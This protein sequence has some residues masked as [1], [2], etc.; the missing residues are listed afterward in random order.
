[1]AG[2]SYLPFSFSDKTI[3]IPKDNTAKISMLYGK[4]V[5]VKIVI[6]S[7]SK[8]YLQEAES[9][10]LE[11]TSTSGITLTPKEGYDYVELPSYRSD[12]GNYTIKITSIIVT[13]SPSETE[14]IEK[15]ETPTIQIT[16][17]GKN[18][19]RYDESSDIY[20]F[21]ANPNAAASNATK[22]IA[23]KHPRY[24]HVGF[25]AKPGYITKTLPGLTQ[26][27][28][29]Y[30][31]PK[32]SSYWLKSEYPVIDPI[33]QEEI[34]YDKEYTFGIVSLN[35]IHGFSDKVTVRYKFEKM[36]P[37]AIDIE[38]SKSNGSG[39]ENITQ[40]NG[41]WIVE[42]SSNSPKISF[43]LDPAQTET[44][45]TKDGDDP[46]SSSTIYNE[47]EQIGFNFSYSVNPGQINE[48][49]IFSR[50]FNT[51]TTSSATTT[52]KYYSS[53]ITSVIFKKVAGSKPSAPA[54]KDVTIDG[55]ETLTNEKIP[56]RIGIEKDVM[57]NFGIGGQYTSINKKVFTEKP[58][59]NVDTSDWEAITL[60]AGDSYTFTTDDLPS[61]STEA[62]IGIV[63]TTDTGTSDPLWIHV[64]LKAP[65]APK[66]VYNS[67]SYDNGSERV[68]FGASLD[69]NFTVGEDASVIE[70]C[71]ERGSNS[72]GSEPSSNTERHKL[73]V[74][75][76]APLKIDAEKIDNGRLFYRAGREVEGATVWSEWAWTDFKRES[77][78]PVSL[79]GKY[80]TWLGPVGDGTLVHV[81]E[82]LRIM[83]YYTTNATLGVSNS[84]PSYL[85][86][87]NKDGYVIKLLGSEVINGSWPTSI[88][89]I[90]NEEYESNNYVLKGVYGWVKF[91]N[92]ENNMPEIYLTQGSTA[93]SEALYDML[94]EPEISTDWAL[95]AK[96]EE[97]QN[98]VDRIKIDRVNDFSRYVTVRSL[99]W[100]GENNEFEMAD[101]T[102]IPLYNRFK[103]YPIANYTA[104]LDKNLLYC[105]RGFIGL[106]STTLSIFPNAEILQC[107]GTPNLFAPN[108]I[109]GDVDDKGFIDI[110]AV[111][112][113]VTFRVEGHADGK[114]GFT[115]TI[116]GGDEIEVVNN[117]FEVDLSD[118]N[119]KETMELVV[120]AHLNGM[121]S[122]APAKVRITKRKAEQV[123]SIEEFKTLEFA[124]PD[125]EK[126]YQITG[127]VVIEAKTDKYL[128]VRDYNDA[129]EA[130]MDENE[131]L[132][133]LL[134]K[135]TINPQGW[136]TDFEKGGD[137]APLEIGDVIY[138]FAIKP[139]HDRGNLLGNN[140][141]FVRTIKFDRHVTTGI[142]EY[143]TRNAAPTDNFEFDSR[144]RM[145][146]VKLHG[147]ELKPRVENT[148]PDTKDDFPYI[149]TLDLK[150]PTSM[151]M[152]VFVRTGFAAAY[153]E[154]VGFDLTGIAMIDND[155]DNDTEDKGKY[156]FALMS[157]EGTAQVAAPK[158]FI[159]GQEPTNDEVLDI[160]YT[161]TGTIKM[162]AEAKDTENNDLG[163]KENEKVTIYYTINGLDPLKDIYRHEY[164]ENAPELA[165]GDGDIEVRAFAAAPGKTPSAVVTRRFKKNSH[166]V[167]F[168]LNFLQSAKEGEAYRFTGDTKV[169]AMG[170]D[171]MFVVGRVGHYLP[172]ELKG[173]WA[174]KTDMNI[175]NG[176]LLTGFTVRF[177]ED[178][179]GNR[180]AVADEFESTF[181]SSG[182]ADAKFTHEPDVTDAL[183]IEKHPRRL[184]TLKGVTASASDAA[185]IRDID[186]W[187]IA[188][189]GDHGTHALKVGMLG[190]VD[191]YTVDEDG[192]KQ[193]VAE[194]FA[195]GATYDITGFVMLNDP[196]KEAKMEVWPL[197]AKLLR[198]TAAVTATIGDGNTQSTNGAGE[199]TASFEGMTMVSL[200][201]PSKNSKIYYAFDQSKG[202]SPD[203]LTW[204]EYQHEFA[205]TKDTYIHAKA[206]AP[207]AVESD[208]TH[209]VLTALGKSGDVEFNV[210][211]GDGVTTLTIAPAAGA[212]AGSTIWYSEGN[213]RSCN[214][215]YT[216]G[217][218]LKYTE[219]TTVYACIQEPGKAKGAVSSIRVMVVDMPQGGGNGNDN[220]KVSGKVVF[221]I[222]D[223]SD[224]TKVTVYL[225][226]EEGLTGTIYYLINPTEQV[227]PENGTKYE[228]PIEMK[229]G[230]RIMAIL[231]EAGKLAGE[232]TDIAVWLIPTDIDG[233]DAEER[234]G[235]IRAEGGSIIAPEGSE[236][237]D[238]TGRRV[239]AT[240]LHAGI[241]IVRTPGG[242]AVKVK[243]D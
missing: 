84:S 179:N 188:E 171:Y 22:G 106:A 50:V 99:K 153:A 186:K 109:K 234:E 103:E 59:G 191:V 199:I 221:T 46:T 24:A 112:D 1:M 158:V 88:T 152:D 45:Y 155:D 136:A 148:D 161:G 55:G 146:M 132:R 83:G 165:L 231:V 67:G 162:T 209:I 213:D 117:T 35:E 56:S 150:T 177:H 64:G 43:I 185:S 91:V 124:N 137:V 233:I 29:L 203:N 113:K 108:P 154:G 166:D 7:L 174:D 121:K 190:D 123:A 18:I 147:V 17:A 14:T 175:S 23:L 47:G 33:A 38:A 172:I 125:P 100:L 21:K 2:D 229:E 58:S 134:I 10:N 8:D 34:D 85:Y 30:N 74:N 163:L 224:P 60:G 151:R 222:D 82:E 178:E 102:R 119:D 101:G 201:C 218:E 181:K 220:A 217:T 71:M 104:N 87:L 4:I 149:Y 49:K 122:L 57:M 157:F 92:N 37:P 39:I 115:Y 78:T 223:T 77:V 143:E 26:S 196:S 227:T 15:T 130:E 116:D 240:G 194:G 81:D 66:I 5:K 51:G 114:S 16:D 96:G 133:R 97:R 184:V 111:S 167:Q 160:D 9:T 141:G 126:I 139:T 6:Q 120:Y 207:N 144:Y 202:F 75:D 156:A 127:K 232:P 235:N 44:R 31:I 238:I 200:V 198:K 54:L 131:H 225:A 118:L 80:T 168:I 145:V 239:N 176:D 98:P 187:S 105:V 20:Y 52:K 93:N 13:W 12:I 36:T 32:S 138:G 215:V 79:S 48:V 94:P 192:N 41:N 40:Q 129:P 25:Y 236:V 27:G 212:A 197:E 173:G 230:G 243:V 182:P 205:V 65:D 237:Y 73:I 90:S 42:Y 210:T 28:S 195:D 110:Q 159:D 19:V 242:K 214:K 128:Y 140:D 142:G 107:P 89:G 68:V 228:N 11:V 63:K 183:D 61:G 226:P 169:V 193:P 180:I 62:W 164:V 211:P 76:S 72:D 70:Y 95:T 206:V 208:H 69:A 53:D 135:N 170:G 204:Y 216:A 241:Y 86:V 189:S 219:E 3:T